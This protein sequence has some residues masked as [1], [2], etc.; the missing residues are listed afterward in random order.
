MIQKV[1]RR[2]VISATVIT[3]IITIA[4]CAQRTSVAHQSAP[5]RPIVV[6]VRT[7][8]AVHLDGKLDEPVWKRAPAYAISLSA[9]ALA[10]GTILM[11]AGIIR[12]AW[13][14]GYV[15]VAMEF[16]DSDVVTESGGDQLRQQNLGDVGEVFLRPVGRS[17]YWELHV[18]PNG[19]KSAFF[20][21]SRGRMLPSCFT[22]ASGL[23]AAAHVEGTLNRWQ[24]KDRGW[25][26]ELAMPI[27]ELVKEGGVIGPDAHW[28]ILAGRYNYSFYLEELELS[29]YPRLSRTYFHLTGE[30]AS[31]RFQE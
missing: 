6:A 17:C 12:V 10:Q 26:A 23:K 31:L 27:A 9:D 18:T 29:A 25:T 22:Y 21:P 4:G 24:D 20:F 30:Y 14:D 7:S 15:Y 3:F 19:R 8:N 11:E 16:T 2:N 5:G 13:D 28:T 1:R